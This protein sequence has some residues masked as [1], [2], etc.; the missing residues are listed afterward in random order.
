MKTYSKAIGAGIGGG[1]A[2]AG[3]SIAGLPPGSPWYAYVIMTVVTTVL[4]A[5]ITYFAPQNAK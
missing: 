3:V 5:L 1:L 4:P 2:G